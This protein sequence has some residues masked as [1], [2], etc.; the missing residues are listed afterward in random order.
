V[1]IPADSNTLI[2]GITITGGNADGVSP[3]NI[4]INGIT[5][6]K[7]DGG[8]ICNRNSS[9]ILINVIISGNK[10]TNNGGGMYNNSFSSPTLVN[11]TISG[12]NANYGG[13]MRNLSSSPIL[14]NVTISGN[15]AND[16]GGMSNSSSSPIL[17]NVTISGNKTNG[18]GG[19]MYNSFS[20]PKINNTIIYG[21]TAGTGNNVFNFNISSVPV[22][23]HSLVGG[24]PL[25]SGIIS[26][27][28]PKFVDWI[29][30]SSATMPNTLGDYSLQIGSP[31]INVGDN[32]LYL[33]ARGI[34]DFTGETDLADNPRLSGFVI[35]IGAF[36]LTVNITP[37]SVPAFD[38]L[39]NTYAL[40]DFPIN[41]TVF[42]KDSD[43]LTTI[44]VTKDK[45]AVSS[46]AI[47]LNFTPSD[48]GFY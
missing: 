2:D 19:G 37:P 1:D 23:D 38:N 21:N 7:S 11:V 28:D 40:G 9:P 44:R 18:N 12:N 31:A 46:G 42:G 27:A 10:A 41:I 34:I 3:T 47:P 24:E 43:K 32:Q 48:T 39:K 4:S 15:S 6:A 20:S 35:D 22:Y 14:T 33:D 45:V 30:P 8:G 36:E 29:D 17:T 13:G 16:G 25:G 5:I 26:N